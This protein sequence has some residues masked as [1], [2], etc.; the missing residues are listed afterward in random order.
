MRIF[1]FLY[2]I[3]VQSCINNNC[4]LQFHMWRWIFLFYQDNFRYAGG[5]EAFNQLLGF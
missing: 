5:E 3:I 2:T 1:L 4:E